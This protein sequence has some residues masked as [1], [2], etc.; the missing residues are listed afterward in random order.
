[1]G[2]ISIWCSLELRHEVFMCISFYLCSPLSFFLFLLI[3]CWRYFSRWNFNHVF[4][5][6]LCR[7]NTKSTIYV[8]RDYSMLHFFRARYGPLPINSVCTTLSHIQIIYCIGGCIFAKV[9][10]PQFLGRHLLL[11]VFVF[12]RRKLA[13][14][15][16]CFLK[17]HE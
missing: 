4:V 6:L 7:G 15:N 10:W 14:L 5:W 2:F 3:F 1:M 9:I 8:Q 13:L 17:V 11:F 16:I 12:Q